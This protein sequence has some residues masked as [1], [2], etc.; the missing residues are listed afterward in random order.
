MLASMG[1]VGGGGREALPYSNK[2]YFFTLPSGIIRTRFAFVLAQWLMG[3]P[4]KGLERIPPVKDS[5]TKGEARNTRGTVL[6]P[7]ASFKHN[8][9]ERMRKSYRIDPSC[10]AARH[11]RTI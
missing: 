5:S 7:L 10:A 4:S 6:G 8:L 3:S 9:K 11:G 1:K 2:V